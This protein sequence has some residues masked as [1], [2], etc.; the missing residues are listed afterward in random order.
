MEQQTSK[1]EVKQPINN[2]NLC[3]ECGGVLIKQGGC[4]HCIRCDYGKC[5][6]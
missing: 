3:P 2:P 1:Q 4:V 5:D 6:L